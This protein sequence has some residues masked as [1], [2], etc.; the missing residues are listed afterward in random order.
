MTQITGG[1]PLNFSDENEKKTKGGYTQAADS[2]E[3]TPCLSKT[4]KR[5]YFWLGNEQMGARKKILSLT[6]L[7]I[8]FKGELDR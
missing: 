8:E 5:P 7:D 6:F 1:N 2:T 4:K 3:Q